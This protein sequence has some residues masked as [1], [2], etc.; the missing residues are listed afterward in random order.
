MGGVV[1]LKYKNI[2]LRKSQKSNKSFK[3]KKTIK[4]LYTHSKQYLLATIQ[5][6]AKQNLVVIGT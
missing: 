2:I 6:V 5:R 4:Y 1:K 3:N